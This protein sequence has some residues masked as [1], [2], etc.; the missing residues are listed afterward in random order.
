VSVHFIW[1]GP[2]NGDRWERIQ[3]FAKLR[4]EHSFR[5]CCQ[6]TEHGAFKA[7]LPQRITVVGVDP[8]LRL[9]GLPAG[10]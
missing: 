5:L 10:A 3:D 1:W 8:Q 7:A 2:F 4:L 9:R 6:S